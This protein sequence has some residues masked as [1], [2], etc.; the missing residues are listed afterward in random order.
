MAGHRAKSEVGVKRRKEAGGCRSLATESPGTPK[1]LWDNN[2][3]QQSKHTVPLRRVKG[4]AK[5]IA[6]G[7]TKPLAWRR[8]AVSG[9][10][11]FALLARSRILVWNQA[12]LTT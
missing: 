4:Q 8:W 6:K 11:C 10:C 12:P 5:G 2:L 1:S 3:Q 9:L 7:L